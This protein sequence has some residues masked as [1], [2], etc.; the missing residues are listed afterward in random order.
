ML[1]TTLSEPPTY[2]NDGTTLVGAANEISND[3]RLSSRRPPNAMRDEVPMHMTDTNKD[4][5]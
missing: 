3:P 2:Y 4:S 1:M 5:P